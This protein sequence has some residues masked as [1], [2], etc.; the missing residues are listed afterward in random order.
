MHIYFQFQYTENTPI[1]I[2]NVASPSENEYGIQPIQ[3]T[4]HKKGINIPTVPR[5]IY[6][7]EKVYINVLTPCIQTKQNNNLKMNASYKATFRILLRCCK[8]DAP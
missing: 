5:Y 7:T 3:T 6:D 2:P 4:V 8:F 1:A